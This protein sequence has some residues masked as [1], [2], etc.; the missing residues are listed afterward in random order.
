M[1]GL[2]QMFFKLFYISKDF[3]VC[4]VVFE[5]C[6]K[7]FGSFGVFVFVVGVE[8]LGDWVID[9]GEKVGSSLVWWCV[10]IKVDEVLFGF[11]GRVLIEYVFFIDDQDFVY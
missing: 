7:F 5:C 11:V 4:F 8:L 1:F 6:F 3:F 9:G 2:L 10:E